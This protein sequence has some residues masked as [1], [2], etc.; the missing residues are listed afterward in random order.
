MNVGFSKGRLLAG[1][2]LL[3]SKAMYTSEPLLSKVLFSVLF[4]ELI[5][6]LHPPSALHLIT[7]ISQILTKCLS[8]VQIIKL[9]EL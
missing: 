8:Y 4:Y 7:S 1:S 3:K 6:T 5:S 2:F 9:Q